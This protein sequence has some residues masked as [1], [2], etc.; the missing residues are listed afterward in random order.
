MT[1]PHKYEDYKKAQEHY[2]MTITDVKIDTIENNIK[3]LVMENCKKSLISF[4]EENRIPIKNENDEEQDEQPPLLVGD[5]SGK[6][7][8][9]TQEA[10]IRTH[11]RKLNKFVR[12]IDYIILDSKIAMINNSTL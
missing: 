10:T 4:K 3:D 8:P 12:L 9:Y 2:R 11:Y 6:E 7:M 5:E 1:E